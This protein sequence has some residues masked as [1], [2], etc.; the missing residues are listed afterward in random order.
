MHRLPFLH[1]SPEDAESER[2]ARAHDA[3]DLMTTDFVT[4]RPDAVLQEVIDTMVGGRH[5]L[6]AVVDDKDQLMGVVD[7]ADVLRGM[8]SMR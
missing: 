8:L 4:A 1:L 6:V 5:K 2:H 3:R 7:R